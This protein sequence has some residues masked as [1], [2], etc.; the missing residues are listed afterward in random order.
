MIFGDLPRSKPNNRENGKMASVHNKMQRLDWDHDAMT[1][2]DHDAVNT[3]YGN[4][5]Q[6]EEEEVDWVVAMTP[7]QR[8]A[9]IKREEKELRRLHKTYKA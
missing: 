6:I 9:Q 1:D 7:K 8:K 3:A 5:Q 2:E 4:I